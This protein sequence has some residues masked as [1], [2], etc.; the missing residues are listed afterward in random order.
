MKL[1]VSLLC[2]FLI[3][4]CTGSLSYLYIL[5]RH[6]W[7]RVE[8]LQRHNYHYRN[9]GPVVHI[10][11]DETTQSFLAQNQPLTFGKGPSP[12]V[13]PEVPNDKLMQHINH[14]EKQIVSQLRNAVTD[15]GKSFDAGEI[16]NSYRVMYNGSKTY[17]LQP[18]GPVDRL[19]CSAIKYV[20]VNTFVKGHPYFRKQELDQYFMDSGLMEGKTYG[21][22]GV[23]SSSGSLSKSGLGSRID[24]DEFVI[25][26][27]NAPVI[28]YEKDVG[29]K[30]SL[31]IVNSQVVGK[32]QFRFLESKTRMY[33]KAPVLVWDPSGYN[34]TTADWYANPDYPFFETFFAKRLMRPNESMYLL[35]PESL[36][37]IW[38]W[39]QSY[40]RYPLLP[41]PP[42]SGFLGLILA[43]KHCHEV[44]IYEYVPSMRLT[45]KCHYYD[46]EENLGCTIGDWHPLAAE[47]LMALALNVADKTA[48][49]SDGYLTLKGA[50][51]FDCS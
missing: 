20:K 39:L 38:N 40:N 31:R 28:G 51:N 14:Y 25:R 1:L 49:Y 5:W 27:N 26:F 15:T 37:S 10:R 8:K 45:K 6:Y 48:V 2:I 11:F 21:T 17:E 33:S 12:V 30:T 46:E 32:P 43:L 42:S 3:L 24:N 16:K 22:C 29:T 13:L 23:V 35:R 44:H 19:V 50:P 34:S 41:N 18:R 36:W 9:P 4:L 7:I 47:K